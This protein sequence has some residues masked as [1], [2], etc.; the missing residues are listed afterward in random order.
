DPDSDDGRGQ[1]ITAVSSFPKSPLPKLDPRTLK[2]LG[3]IPSANH[4]TTLFTAASKNETVL[5]GYVV[6]LLSLIIVWPPQ[7]DVL[8][9][10]VAGLGS[11]GLIRMLYRQHVIRSQ[12]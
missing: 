6:L 5:L 12:L 1:T 8:L 2:S 3:S 10:T 7:K 9:K 4:I 11:G